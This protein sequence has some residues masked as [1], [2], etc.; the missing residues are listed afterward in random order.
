M[1]TPFTGGCLCGAIRYTLDA[2]VR[3]LRACHCTHCQK[4]SG[5]GGSVYAVVPSSALTF[6]EGTPKRHEAKADSG[7]MLFRFFCADCGS[8]I[9]AH[10]ETM[11]ELW[12]LRVGTLDDPGELK[13]TAHSWT[14]SARSWDHIDPGTKQFPRQSDSPPVT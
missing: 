4:A 13:I 12:G 2:E 6:T 5:A 9:Y 14:R 1:P 3:E 10:R 11:P 8:P 7:R